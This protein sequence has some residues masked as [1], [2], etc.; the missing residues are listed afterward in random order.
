M[1]YLQPRG[2]PLMCHS[3][4]EAGLKRESIPRHWLQHY[5]PQWF[6]TRVAQLLLIFL[7]VGWQA[8]LCTDLWHLNWDI[9]LPDHPLKGIYLLPF[10]SAK[11]TAFIYLFV[12]FQGSLP[13]LWREMFW[14]RGII[15]WPE[16][17]RTE[18]RQRG[19]S[20][21]EKLPRLQE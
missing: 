1:K 15:P 9:I 5:F 21:L 7:K 4:L 12:C 18:S 20:A 2:S 3:V 13:I 17:W 11:W 16:K 6:G 10:F 8:T 14:L 19:L